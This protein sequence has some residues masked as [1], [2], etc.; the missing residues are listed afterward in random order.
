MWSHF[1]DL[2]SPSPSSSTPGLNKDGMKSGLGRT[3]I[4]ITTHYIEEARSAH[5]VGMMRFGKLLEEGSPDTLIKRYIIL[6]F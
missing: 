1:C 2:T 4:V 5:R 6:V 3:A